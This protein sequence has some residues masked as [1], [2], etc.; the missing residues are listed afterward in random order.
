MLELT[1]CPGCQAELA[2][3]ATTESTSTNLAPPRLECP[4]CGTHFAAQGA[5]QR[6]IPTAKLAKPAAPAVRAEIKPTGTETVERSPLLKAPA[7]E[8]E[9]K[10]SLTKL[11]DLL[12]TPPLRPIVAPAKAES[13]T[14]PAAKPQAAT[15]PEVELPEIT[16]PQLKDFIHSLAP[17]KV[18]PPTAARP[19]LAKTVEF[20]AAESEAMLKRDFEFDLSTPEDSTGFNPFASGVAD[21]P[22]AHVAASEDDP[23]E[24]GWRLTRRLR[25]AAIVSMFT[26]ACGLGFLVFRPESSP[27]SAPNKLASVSESNLL[28]GATE[29]LSPSDEPAPKNDSAIEPATFVA[30]ESPEPVKPIKGNPI[31]RGAP[32]YGADDLVAALEGAAEAR[33]HLQTHTLDDAK[34]VAALGRNYAR[35]CYLAQVYALLSDEAAA[36]SLRQRIAA[37]DQFSLLFESARARSEVSK[38]A[39]PW[40]A[41]KNKPHGGVFFCGKLPEPIRHGE[42]FEYPFELVP[43]EVLPVLLDEAADPEQFGRAGSNFAAVIGVLVENP[44]ERLPD[45]TGSA[46][47]VVW[48]RELLPLREP[49]LE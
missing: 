7:T 27:P 1:T 13:S 36:D 28:A 3:P 41:W 18:P 15:L 24:L 47:Q 40:I 11:A 33:S 30:E 25:N 23:T 26:A 42:L 49:R 16:P 12:E 37:R 20:S 29:L 44:A 5:G 43:G 35:L 45:Y 9:T 48:C 34:E 31:L 2:A 46:P 32:T 22:V 21:E 8:V 6:R 14:P 38:I 10:S 4:L 19:E 17:P 39:G